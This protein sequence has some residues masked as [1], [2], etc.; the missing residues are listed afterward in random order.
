MIRFRAFAT[1]GMAVALLASTA[2]SAVAA[3]GTAD[4][5][6]PL[7]AAI[8]AYQRVY[9]RI[10]LDAATRAASQQDERKS[11]YEAIGTDK[12]FG[13]AYFDPPTGILHIAA[14]DPAMGERAVELGKRQGLEV[15]P[16]L[17]KRSYEELQG[18]ANS[19]RSGETALGKATR[20]NIGISVQANQVIAAVP[21]SQV[22]TL[23]KSAPD[24]VQVVADPGVKTEED[25]CTSRA[26]CDTTIHAGN[27]LWRSFAG[28]N[29]CSVG[30][31]ARDASNQRFTYTAGHCSNGNGVAWGTGTRSIGPMQAS[32][33]F[34]FLDASIIRVANPWF[35]FDTG[36]EIYNE[37]F[38]NRTVNVNGVAPNLG[39][40]WVGDVTCLSANFTQPNGFNFCGVIGS[41]MDFSVRGMVRVNG[42]DACPG[43]SGGGWYW[44]TNS[45][46][47]WAYGLHS[48]SDEGCHGSA[49][50]SHSWFSALP[51]VKAFFTPGLN[52]ETRP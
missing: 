27:M 10:S 26:F 11:L 34:S 40:I 39:F 37:F 48:R 20:G 49:G 4:Q 33:N 30:F 46:R 17:V 43:D 41:T 19:L 51:L 47:R 32:V 52:V 21:A 5:K 44:L 2:G 14:T 13:G 15:E 22:E 38:P 28:N 18:I 12:S 35:A 8:S 7:D 16:Q 50:G 45:G 36:G 6:D 3:D 25:A 24:G 9:P 29:V 23:A 31:T 42:L 1:A